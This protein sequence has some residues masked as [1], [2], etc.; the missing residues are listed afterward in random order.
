MVEK[1][2]RIRHISSIMCSFQICVSQHHV[3]CP[4]RLWK[5]NRQQSQRIKPSMHLSL[6]LP[7]TP[8][9][10]HQQPQTSWCFIQ[11][12]VAHFYPRNLESVVSPALTLL[13]PCSNTKTRLDL[14]H[15]IFNIHVIWSWLEVLDLLVGHTESC[16]PPPTPHCNV[17]FCQCFSGW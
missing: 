2:T 13:C 14:V 11:I 1:V 8:F 9:N 16:F 10:C 3:K 15:Y 12:R 5:Y 17:L 7:I 4:S 6:T